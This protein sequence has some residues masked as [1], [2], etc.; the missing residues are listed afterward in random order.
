M[1]SMSSHGFRQQPP[2]PR[3]N[4]PHGSTTAEVIQLETKRPGLQSAPWTC[5]SGTS[6]KNPGE[7][8]DALSC[9]L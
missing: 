6:V 4:G 7:K 8:W 3:R 9:D 1:S 2:K 5:T